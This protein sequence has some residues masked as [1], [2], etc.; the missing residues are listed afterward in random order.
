MGRKLRISPDGRYG[1]LTTPAATFTVEDAPLEH[2]AVVDL[3]SG[4]V[5]M[6][7]TI[8]AETLFQAYGIEQEGGLFGYNPIFEEIDYTTTLEAEFAG[9]GAIL[10]TGTLKMDD[11]SMEL[12]YTKNVVLP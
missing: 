3:Q 1:V 10:L 5:V 11:G 8:D 2:A 12:E 4:E 7:D 6:R 9:E